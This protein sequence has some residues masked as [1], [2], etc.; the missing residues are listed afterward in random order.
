MYT[1]WCKPLC[2]AKLNTKQALM[3]TILVRN[4]YNLTTD[5]GAKGSRKSFFFTYKYLMFLE[6]PEMD[7][8]HEKNRW[9]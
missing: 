1:G 8:L 2:V 9:Y 5:K 4:W 6:Y 3:H 7:D